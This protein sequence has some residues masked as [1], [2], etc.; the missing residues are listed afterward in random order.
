MAF[1]GY[2]F[3]FLSVPM[4][5]D[6][7]ADKVK[8]GET[9]TNIKIGS[10]MTMPNE[11]RWDTG[12]NVPSIALWDAVG[13]RIGQYKPTKYDRI[14]DGTVGTAIEVKHTQTNPQNIARQ[15]E[16]ISVVMDNVDAIC[17]NYIAV[18]GPDGPLSAWYGDV[19]MGCGANW[20]HSQ[21]VIGDKGYM[22]RCTWLDKDHTNGLPHNA[23]GMHIVDFQGSDE[24]ATQYQEF[25][26]SMCKSAPRFKLYED[27]GPD[28]VIPVY[29]PQ[30]EYNGDRTDTDPEAVAANQG[31]PGGNPALDI[32]QATPPGESPNPPD[33]IAIKILG[34]L[35]GKHVVAD[36]SF[37][38]P[39]P[40]RRR[41]TNPA[42]SKFDGHLIM[43]DH[44]G[45]SAKELC[46]HDHSAGPDFVSFDENLFCD[47][48]EKTT[49][50][51]CTTPGKTND[52]KAKE[53]ADDMK[54]G[55]PSV[56]AIEVEAKPENKPRENIAFGCFD[57]ETRT[58][59]GAG[60]H[61]RD[62]E[63]GRR[64]PDKA[65]GSFQHWK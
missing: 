58:M 52:Q 63:D 29:W 42:G 14:Y 64:V 56:N 10:G 34:G 50:P 41:W 6:F 32:D 3:M 40:L 36:R 59:R 47:M 9:K 11:T 2:L 38:S 17:I 54:N 62:M 61:R 5:Y 15:P 7:Y 21:N 13:H 18:Q 46:E 57:T 8:A 48:S 51:L 43:S 33:S 27:L 49:W 28:D 22:P 44:V 60:P 19:G 1:I 26:D 65:Y 37:D 24:R 25:K 12:G 16:Y 23:M 20:Y 4:L 53:N 31:V 30:L 45:Q 35:M 55:E 39:A